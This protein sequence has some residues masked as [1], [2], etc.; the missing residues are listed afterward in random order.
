MILPFKDARGGHSLCREAQVYERVEISLVEV[1]ERV[2]KSVIWV[3][4]RTKKGQR[5]H[6]Y[7]FERDEKT[8]WICDIYQRGTFTA[9]VWRDALFQTS[10]KINSL[11]QYCHDL[12]LCAQNTWNICRVLVTSG[13]LRKTGLTRTWWRKKMNGSNFLRKHFINQIEVRVWY[14]TLPRT[15]LI[16]KTYVKFYC[17]P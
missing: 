9:S 15:W 11:Q 13:I 2:R 12:V 6:F 17:H 4:K 3:Y 5:R 14:H 10:S 1:Y 8:S 16:T 7:G